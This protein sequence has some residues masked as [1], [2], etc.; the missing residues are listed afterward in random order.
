MEQRERFDQDKTAKKLLGKHFQGHKTDVEEL[1]KVRKFYKEIR[2]NFTGVNRALGKQILELSSDKFLDIADSVDAEL[3]E[4][5]INLYDKTKRFYTLS[6]LPANKQE[7]FF[8]KKSLKKLKTG[9]NSFARILDNFI[10]EVTLNS[11]DSVKQEMPQLLESKNQIE[12]IL[13]SSLLDLEQDD[14]TVQLDNLSAA[15]QL[16]DT[17]NKLELDVINALLTNTCTFL[18]VH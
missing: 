4:K 2:K 1:I 9:M 3:R 18:Q 16:F 13:D 11:L 7:K 17:A 8:S 15:K 12:S 10:P 5:T 14:L 6:Q